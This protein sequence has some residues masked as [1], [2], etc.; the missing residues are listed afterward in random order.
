MQDSG[1]ITRQ[2]RLVSRRVAAWTRDPEPAL[3]NKL[4]WAQKNK[5][6]PV[7]SVLLCPTSL[8]RVTSPC[9]NPTF[10]SAPFPA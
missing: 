1:T 4:Q 7:G 2:L 6:C 9:R 5:G 8:N 10:A 3:A